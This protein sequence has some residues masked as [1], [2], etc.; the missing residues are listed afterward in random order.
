MTGPARPLARYAPWVRRGDFVFLSGVVPL[1]AAA[2]RV[3]RGFADLPPGVPETIGATGE[4]SAD[5][6]DGPIL[7]QSWFVLDRVRATIED[8]GGTM[9]DVFKLVQYFTNLDHFPR[10]NAVRRRFFPDAPPVSTVVEVSGLMPS[11]EVLVEVEATAWLPA[12]R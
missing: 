10:Y 6:R 11:A 3:V 4:F 5:A 9:A 8:A 2:G 1:D 12:T 7:A